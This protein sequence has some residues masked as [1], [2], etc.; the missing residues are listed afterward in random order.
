[1]VTRYM[2]LRRAIANLAAAP[3]AQ[4]AY[5]DGLG[6][7]AYGN[8]ELALEFDDIFPVTEH[9]RRHGEIRQSE[10]DAIRP[11]AEM[12]DFTFNYSDAS[13]WERAALYTDQRWSLIR[14]CAAKALLDLPDDDRESDYT[15]GLLEE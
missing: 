13:F 4:V 5:L 2:T 12:L 7:A 9:M 3:D 1:M 15:R 14:R 6:I 10:I 8:D 11:L